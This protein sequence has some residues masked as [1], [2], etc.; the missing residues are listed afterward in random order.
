MLWITVRICFYRFK[1]VYLSAKMNRKYPN[2]FNILRDWNKSYENKAC[3]KKKS[4]FCQHFFAFK[5]TLPS[6]IDNLRHLC[7][8]Y[9]RLGIGLKSKMLHV[10]QNYPILSR[11]Y[12]RPHVDIFI[13]VAKKLNWNRGILNERTVIHFIK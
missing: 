10:K 9:Y 6:G 8:V 7:M 3:L 5:V 12:K 1:D 2:M 11:C 13:C 4:P